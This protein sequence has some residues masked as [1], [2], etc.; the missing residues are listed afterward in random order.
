MFTYSCMSDSLSLSLCVFYQPSLWVV[1][2]QVLH[3][4]GLFLQSLLWE[5][6]AACHLS[7]KHYT[8]WCFN[9]PIFHPSSS[10]PHVQPLNLFS[11][12]CRFFPYLF[13]PADAK[14]SHSCSTEAQEAPALSDIL[15]IPTEDF[16]IKRKSCIA[17]CHSINSSWTSCVESFQELQSQRTGSNLRC[18]E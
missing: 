13:F 1:T 3:L 14:T 16:K 7:E 8:Y 11:V 4:V 5:Q 6:L 2:V 15:F 9:P 17:F 12:L 18:C 10:F